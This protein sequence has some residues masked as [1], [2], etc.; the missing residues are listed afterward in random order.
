MLGPVDAARTPIQ[1]PDVMRGVAFTDPFTETTSGLPNG[2]EGAYTGGSYTL[3]PNAAKRATW[4]TYGANY[5]DATIESTLQVHTGEGAAGLVFW[6]TSSD[7][8]YLF[9]ITVDGFYQLVRYQRGGWA[10]L[11]GWTKSAAIVANGPNKLGIKTSGAKITPLINGQALPA[12]TAPTAGNGRVGLL[13]TTF[14]QPGFVAQFT[15]YSVAVTP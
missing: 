15:Q 1:A 3:S 12:A 7:D 8:Y 14:E 10:T 5:A 2:G 4:A 9:L 11:I 6:Q 13:A